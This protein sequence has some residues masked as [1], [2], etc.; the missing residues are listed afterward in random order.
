MKILKDSFISSLIYHKSPIR[1][2]ISEKGT[3]LL[4]K[5]A[6]VAN[7]IISDNCVIDGTILNSIIFPGVVVGENSYIKDSIILPNISI[8]SSSYIIKTIIDER[9]NHDPA[10]GPEVKIPDIGNKCNIGTA[11]GN[12]KNNEF[13]SLNN[14]LTLIGKNCRI[15][16]NTRIGGACY[17]ASGRGDSYFKK[18]KHLYNGLSILN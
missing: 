18:N 13:S 5:N 2:F 12:I 8:G 1:S 10:T 3:A 4:G 11:D 7:S 17:I 9:T 16:D 6:K 14:S 15:P